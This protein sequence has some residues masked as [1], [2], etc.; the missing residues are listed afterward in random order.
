MGYNTV[1]LVLNDHM[2]AI[3]KSPLT[4]AWAICHPPNSLQELEKHWWPQVA[5][6]ARGYGEDPG[7]LRNGITILPTFHADDKHVLVAGWNQLIRP[8]PED[9][10][11]NSRKN[12]MR[13][14]MP[15]YWK[16]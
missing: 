3:A 9:C 4:L 15:E 13:V 5:S 2:H 12:E 7:P 8:S 6:V 1:V 11:Y 16:R 14:N 10:K